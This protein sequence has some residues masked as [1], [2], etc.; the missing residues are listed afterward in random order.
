MLL[1]CGFS[2]I[3]DSSRLWVRGRIILPQAAAVGFGLCGS[4][5]YPAF[6]W[7]GVDPSPWLPLLWPSCEGSLP[8]CSSSSVFLRD[9][10]TLS[11]L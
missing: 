10:V 3:R 1:T 9:V 11:G 5:R 7:V 4:T 2:G 8:P 6:S